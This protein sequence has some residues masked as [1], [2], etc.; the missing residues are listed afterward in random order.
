MSLTL[1]HVAR[2][3]RAALAGAI[4]VD[5]ATDQHQPEPPAAEPAEPV[6]EFGPEVPATRR[7]RPRWNTAGFAAALAADRRAVPLAAV[8][9]GVA[10]FAS[11]VSEW[12]VTAISPE[13]IGDNTPGFRSV[14]TDVAG[15]GAWGGGYLVGLFLLAGAI[16]LVMFG[17]P[18]GARY[19]RLVGLSTGG[20]LLAMLA[21][22]ASILGETSLI[23]GVFVGLVGEDQIR[24]SYGRGIWCALFGVAMAVLALYLAGRHQGTGSPGWSW[25]RGRQPAAEEDDE[26]PPAEPFELTVGPATPFT[27]LTGDRDNSISG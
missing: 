19:A 24:P 9:A 25:R 5:M 8:L 23:S 10:L 1:V 27:S 13:L 3:G 11:L 7:G 26:R 16:V 17:P 4:M 6:V 14:P 2:T 15:L 20:V 21:A 12:Q 22:L 18:A